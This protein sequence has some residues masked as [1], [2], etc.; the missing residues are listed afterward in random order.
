LGLGL[1]TGSGSSSTSLGSFGGRTGVGM[2]SSSSSAVLLPQI[3]VSFD[4]SLLV[5]TDQL[6]L[7]IQAAPILWMASGYLSSA[8]RTSLINATTHPY[9]FV[10]DDMYPV[11]FSYW[12]CQSPD[13]PMPH[14]TKQFQKGR[15]S[16]HIDPPRTVLLHR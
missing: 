4:Q 5:P 9:E 16:I 6:I 2:V 1:T 8:Q 14:V 3:I 11:D 12:F 10:Y 7:Q 15:A 13:S